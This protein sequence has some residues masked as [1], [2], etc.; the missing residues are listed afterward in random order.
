MSER[1]RQT[2]QDFYAEPNQHLLTVLK[3]LRGQGMV[4]T[5]A[6]EWVAEAA[7]KNTYST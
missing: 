3:Q 6:P 7:A 2:L 1:A 5:R 4:V